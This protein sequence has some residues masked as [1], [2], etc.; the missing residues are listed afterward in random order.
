MRIFLSHTQKLVHSPFKA[1]ATQRIMSRQAHQ[2]STLE[3]PPSAKKHKM[4]QEDKDFAIILKQLG[5]KRTHTSMPDKILRRCKW[6]YPQVTLMKQSPRKQRDTVT[7]RKK[8]QQEHREPNDE[9]QSTL[10]NSTLVWLTCPRIR[11]LV[12]FLEFDK[13]MFEKIRS[14]FGVADGDEKK[15]SVHQL[16]QV[17]EKDLDVQRIEKGRQMLMQ[18]HKNFETFLETLLS[19]EEMSVWRTGKE[20]STQEQPTIRYGN[21]GSRNPYTIKCLHAHVAALLAGSQDLVGMHVVQKLFEMIETKENRKIGD[22]EDL[23][24]LDC[25]SGCVRC[26]QFEE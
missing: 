18:S 24:E 22:I 14:H 7:V 10:V 2:V 17:Q 1:S 21:G 15:I 8:K 12:G 19:P 20:N 23:H 16:L 9:Q 25:P 13:M 5:R 11:E 6:G 3:E 26:K 4:S